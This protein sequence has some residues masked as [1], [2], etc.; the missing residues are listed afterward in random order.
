M[1]SS[2]MLPNSNNNQPLFGSQ[3]ID[4]N[5][6]TP[7]SDAT[8]TKKNNPNHI[9]RPM[10][11]F[12]VWSQI[13]RR[14]IC[15]TQPDMHNAEISKKLGGRW[16]S[17]DEDERLPFKQE[18]E[19]LRLLHQKEYPDY[20]YRP[21][22][23]SNKVS[24]TSS[25]SKVVHATKKIKPKPRGKRNDS[26]NN[27]NTTA[28]ARQVF[29]TI[30]ESVPRR[31]ADVDV[32]SKLKDKLKGGPQMQMFLSSPNFITAH[33]KVPSSPSCDT[34]DSPESASFYDDQLLMDVSRA[35]F[36]P[37]VKEE[38]EEKLDTTLDDLDALT[39]LIQDDFSFE[40]LADMDKHMEVGS[41][42][43]SHL[44][45]SCT[46]DVSDLLSGDWN[47]QSLFTN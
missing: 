17:L 14:K 7:Y 16:R 26:N 35:T 19:K 15:E 34:P 31:A 25:S 39:D 6:A 9:K 33:A 44:N 43:T 41:D 29:E 12:M 30:V 22:K 5:S 27:L 37:Y 28:V 21:R 42:A 38:P 32:T 45:F 46:P 3:K 8:Q 18:A 10:N 2:G 36:P 20:K 4:L 23:K 47:S 40:A 13:E 11:A 24:S 1:D